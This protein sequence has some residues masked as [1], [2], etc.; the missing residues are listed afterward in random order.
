MSPNCF[1]AAAETCLAILF[2]FV[3]FGCGSGNGN[4]TTPPASGFLYAASERGITAFPFNSSTG[5]L[6]MSLI[7]PLHNRNLHNKQRPHQ[8]KTMRIR[9]KPTIA[10]LLCGLAL[11][12]SRAQEGPRQTGTSGNERRGANW[13]YGR[14]TDLTLSPGDRL[15]VIV[16]A[17]D[18]KARPER[19]CSH[20]VH[21]VYE[22]AGFT[23]AYA[24]S[25][26]L[27]VGV[28]EFQR[29]KRPQPGDLVVWR[30]H[31]GIVIRP[32]HH[33]FFSFI[34]IAREADKIIVE[35][36]DQGLGML[37]EKLAEVQS[38]G[39][40]VG[41]S[42]MRERLCHFS[43]ELVVESNGSGTKVYATLPFLKISL[44][45]H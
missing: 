26:D 35:V 23:Y 3:L 2:A 38:Q 21:A 34:R 8:I 37:P 9:M 44:S 17:L 13:N 1:R 4:P 43:G 36:Q 22:R 27:H 41:I 42:G 25:S 28:E 11:C 24:S 15:S 32:S 40:G 20:L 7:P 30:G 19:D 12:F 10:I 18:S 33:V 5:A 45:P 31:V 16:A 29:V 6:G 39:S 14:K